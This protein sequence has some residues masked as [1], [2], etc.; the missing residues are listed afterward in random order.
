MK[1]VGYAGHSHKVYLVRLLF[2]LSAEDT[3]I[4]KP[5]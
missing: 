2:Y 3:G 1:A 4:F 5:E